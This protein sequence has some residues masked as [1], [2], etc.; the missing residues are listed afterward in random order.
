MG[1]AL[2]S[3]AR[4]VDQRQH[5]EPLTVELM[6][7][8][9]R[10]DMA[11][12]N[13]PRTWARRLKILRPFMRWLR[14]FEPRTEIPDDAIFGRVGERTTP[15]IY[16]EQ[17][18]VD[19]L[20]AARH[21]SPALRGATYETLFGL[22]ASAGLRVSEAVCLRNTDVDLKAGM[23][24]I[25]RTKFAKSRQVPMHPST[26]EALRRY[27]HMRDRLA[28]VAEESP[29]F[30]GSRGQRFG[31]QLS[32]R[33]VDNVF[34]K[35]RV[36]LAWPNRGTHSTPRVHDLRHTFVVRRILAWQAEGKDIDQAMLG[37][38][39]YVGHAMV[40]NTYWY[41]TAVPELMATAAAMFESNM[42][43]EV[44]HA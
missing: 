13:D 2:L 6:A 3:F 21:L 41:L 33:Q 9:A 43:Q 44:S 11:G 22:L 42:A 17:E 18:I 37:L 29:F 32:T 7:D 10:H 12:S 16:H 4:Y 1:Y 23:L 25:R 38:S 27:R 30:I 26:V 15:H 8:W 19:L 34:A 14:Q 20:A 24:T 39:T 31:Q 28:E 36:Q 35:L 40:T 5:S